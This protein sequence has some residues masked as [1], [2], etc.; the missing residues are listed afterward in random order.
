M[1]TSKTHQEYEQLL[2]EI[3]HKLPVERVAQVL[4][5]ARFIETQIK[6]ELD[7][8]ETE[9]E[10]AASEAKWDAI[11]ARPEVQERMIQMAEQALAE[12]DAGLAMDMEFDEEGNLIVPEEF[13]QKTH[14]HS[15]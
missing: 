12:A 5:F 9:E 13:K 1:L 3:L 4:D 8:K 11:V 2:V 10:I 7:E 15:L 6:E 14:A